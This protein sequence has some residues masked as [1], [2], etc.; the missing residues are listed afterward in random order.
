MTAIEIL[1][2]SEYV[3]VI[4][5]VRNVVRDKYEIDFIQDQRRKVEI[6][7][8][9]QIYI[10]CLYVFTDLSLKQIALLAGKKDHSTIIHSVQV[11]RDTCFCNENYRKEIIQIESMIE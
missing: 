1:A 2:M 3:P 11:V 9:R 7:T 6:V 4:E 8:P 10:Y 5:K